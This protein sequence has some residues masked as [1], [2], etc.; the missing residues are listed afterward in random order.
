MEEKNEIIE[1]Q[2]HI[3]EEKQKEILDSIHYASRIQRALLTNEKYIYRKLD[4]LN[5]RWNIIY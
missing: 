2:K 1:K 4:S 3:V 5:K